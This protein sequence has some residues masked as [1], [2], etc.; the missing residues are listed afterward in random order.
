MTKHILSLVGTSRKQVVSIRERAN[1]MQI[2]LSQICI[3]R[4]RKLL[5]YLAFKYH[6]TG[7]FSKRTPSLDTVVLRLKR[8]V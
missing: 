2:C 4:N 6:P 8:Y 5:Q 7:E 1:S 3:A